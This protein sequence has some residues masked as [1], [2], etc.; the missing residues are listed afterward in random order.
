MKKEFFRMEDAHREEK[1]SLLRV[2][3][4]FGTIASMQDEIDEDIKEIKEAINSENNISYDLVDEKL[5]VIKQ[6]I[7]LK[8]R[9]SE[10]ANVES[11]PFQ[12]IYDKLLNA[13]KA[14]RQIM[15]ALLDDFYPTKD[16]SLDSDNIRMD[17]NS[18]IAQMDFNKP[19]DDLLKY[20][21]EIKLKISDDFK[22]INRTFI[23]FLNQVK[24]LE[25]NFTNEF[26]GSAPLKE[27]EYFEMKINSEVGLIA[28]SFNIHSTINEVKAVV[29]EKLKNK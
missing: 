25:E 11:D 17:C 2:I 9:K 19:T 15:T 23:S 14:I 8:E 12:D 28:D 10:S 16:E 24:E 20:I 26:G 7:L 6:K 27:I 22:F 4:T 29:G 3:N 1:E 5:C 21:G 18:D 13:C